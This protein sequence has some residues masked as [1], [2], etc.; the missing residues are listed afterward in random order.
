[1]ISF[2]LVNTYFNLEDYPSPVKTYFYDRANVSII[3]GYIN[4]DDARSSK[5]FYHKWRLSCF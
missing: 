2:E 1:M 4:H 5:N 3:T